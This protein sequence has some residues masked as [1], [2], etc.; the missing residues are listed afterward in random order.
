MAGGRAPPPM[1]KSA[2]SGEEALCS[3][4]PGEV[5]QL[6]KERDRKR[7]NSNASF[8]FIPEIGFRFLEIV[9]YPKIEIIPN[10]IGMPEV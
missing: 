2:P 4:C 10:F 3:T 6:P 1:M 7:K 8:I 9:F 5:E